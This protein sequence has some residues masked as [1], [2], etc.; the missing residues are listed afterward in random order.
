MPLNWNIYQLQI[1][2]NKPGLN[3]VARVSRDRYVIGHVLTW[4][5]HGVTCRDVPMILCKLCCLPLCESAM[6]PRT[7]KFVKNLGSCWPITWC[8]KSCNSRRQSSLLPTSRWPTS[9]RSAS[10]HCSKH[11]KLTGLSQ[12]FLS[13]I[14]SGAL[15]YPYINSWTSL[16]KWA[17]IDLFLMQAQRIATVH[18]RFSSVT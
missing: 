7:I 4:H 13:T 5:A 8:Q 1:T 2:L 10:S 12:V 6:L 18:L 9:S 16:A 11:C 3:H 15:A 14:I 17:K